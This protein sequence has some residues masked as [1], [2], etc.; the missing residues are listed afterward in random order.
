MATTKINIPR[1]DSLDILFTVK[2]D[3][4]VPADV[5]G[6]TVYFAISALNSTTKIIEKNATPTPSPNGV[7]TITLT[8]ADTKV[9]E[10]DTKYEYEVRYV[11]GAVR[12]STGMQPW[13]NIKSVIAP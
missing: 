5:G 9:L 12:K 1:G 8:E 13:D 7:A 10:D 11:N 2:V 6:G 4:A 3:G